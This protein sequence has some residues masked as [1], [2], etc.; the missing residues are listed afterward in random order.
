MQILLRAATAAGAKR[1]RGT[2][3]RERRLSGQGWVTRPHQSSRRSRLAGGG[4]GGHSTSPPQR[5]RRGRSISQAAGRQRNGPTSPQ[6]S[7]NP[8]DSW[9]P[10]ASR[11]SGPVDLGVFFFLKKT[12]FSLF[13]G[14]QK[15]C[16]SCFLCTHFGGS[17]NNW[18][19]RMHPKVLVSAGFVN[20]MEKLPLGFSL[21]FLHFFAAYSWFSYLFQNRRSMYRN[22]IS[23]KSRPSHGFLYS[24]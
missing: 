6:T 23:L 12:R 4:E 2:S 21:I 8:L 5:P 16:F 14:P 15:R 3:P 11:A 18:R 22:P 10:M 13:W 1:G 9:S 24:Y 17:K 7:T 20:K 19:G